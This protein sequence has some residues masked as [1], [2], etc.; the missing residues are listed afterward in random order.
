MPKNWDPTVKSSFVDL[1]LRPPHK[2][3]D[4]TEMLIKKSAELGYGSLGIAF[5]ID[6]KQ[7]EIFEIREICSRFGVDLVTRVD[8]APKT[9]KELLKNLA[10]LRRKIEVITVHCYSKEVAR[11]AAKDRRV[12]LISFPLAHPR[13]CF[14]DSAEA[15]LASKASASLEIELAP[16]LS[17]SGFQR[18]RLLSLWRGETDTAKKFGVPIILASGANDVYLLR[19][20]E[21]YAFLSYLFGL[22]FHAA[23]QALSKNPQAIVERNRRK[24]SSNYVAPGIYVIRRGK[25]CRDV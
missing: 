9:V 16:L 2:I 15:E 10:I 21:D 25:D 22:D 3:S 23:K 20:P 7:E 24:L 14:F 13:K 12:D 5:P 1:H 4:Q 17:F 11:Q 18:V 19:K 6:A 8:L